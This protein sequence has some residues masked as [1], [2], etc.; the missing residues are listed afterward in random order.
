MITRRRRKAE[1]LIA[2]LL[3]CLLCCIW[4]GVS[5]VAR[6]NGAE[7]NA[8]AVGAGNV[9][10]TF[11]NSTNANSNPCYLL[12]G[13]MWS[14]RPLTDALL[15]EA[16][17][18]VDV[19]DTNVTVA[20]TNEATVLISYYMVVSA[21][22]HSTPGSAFLSSALQ[23]NGGNKDFLQARIIVNGNPYR[24]SAASTSPSSPYESFV[25]TVGGHLITPLGPGNHSIA[26]QWKRT[27]GAGRGVVTSWSSRPSLSGGFSEARS[28]AV[29]A[30]HSYMWHAEGVRDAKLDTAG[31]WQAVPDLSIAFTLSEPASLRLLY[32]MVVLPD[33]NFGADGELCRC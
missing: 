8:I 27:G 28:L 18:W 11:T 5:A 15:L 10:P 3:V 9:N 7:G 21:A 12:T 22:Q 20:L 30:Q 14:A 24:Q 26:L 23:L 33:Q 13:L 31:A 25:D 6:G 17:V 32:S 1:D 4:P 16:G 29:T 19:P 2:L